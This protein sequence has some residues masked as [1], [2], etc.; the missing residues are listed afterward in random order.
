MADRPV[1]TGF[2]ATEGIVPGGGAR[3]NAF[4]DAVGRPMPSRLQVWWRTPAGYGGWHH[5]AV[6]LRLCARNAFVTELVERLHRKL[7]PTSPETQDASNC[8]SRW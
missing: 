1:R 3:V 4:L 8:C 7:L 6:G 5:V 2:A